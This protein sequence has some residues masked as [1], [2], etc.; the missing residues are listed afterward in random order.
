[1]SKLGQQ[2]ISKSIIYYTLSL[3]G[4]ILMGVTVAPIGAWFL[5]W[6]ALVPL[7]ILVINYTSKTDPPAPRPLPL[8]LLWGIGYH[9]VALSW[10]TGIHPMDWLGVPWLPSLTITLLCW[11]FISLW[12]GILVTV[13]A[14]LMVRL[15]RGNPWLRVL[16]GTAIWC[17]LE[18]LWSASPLWW[19][20]LAYTQSPQN[21]VILHLG[22]L[23]GPNSVTAVIVAFNGL[24]A[25]YLTQRRKGAKEEGSL[26]KGFVNG[27]LILAVSLLIISHFIGFILYTAPL[28]LTSS[29]ALKIGVIQ[30]NI[31]NKIKVLPQ[32]LRRAITGYTE[33]YLNLT[34]QGVQAVLTPE[35]SIPI[36]SRDLL[37]T[38][39]LAAIREKG[40]IAWIGAFGERGNSYTNSLF[41]V[42]GN[43]EVTSRYD[44]SKLVPLGEY[45][46]FENILGGLIQRLSPLEAH[47]VAGKAQ[48]I[49]DTP[50]GKV[51][52][53]ICYESA[54]AE[55]F[56]YQASMGGKFIL[57]SSNDAH[58]TAAMADQHHAQD[59]MR[60]IE[61]DRW[62]VRATNTGY[63]AFINPHGQTL[64]KSAYNTYQTH[65]ETIY[66]RQTQTLYVR[67]GDWLTPLLLVLSALSRIFQSLVLFCDKNPRNPYYS[68]LSSNPEQEPRPQPPPRKR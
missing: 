63:S 37:Q 49:F 3:L 65:A 4:G 35:A 15:D 23:S 57:S 27:Y 9:G 53:G 22:Q 10:I 36:F 17:G 33:G 16:F 31:P 38:P 64:W 6:I 44:K 48:Q 32:G 25:E 18:S 34:N 67:W 5:A 14:A 21:L 1:M 19:S 46:P 43:G 45:I 13:W 56:R 61:T 7:W 24:I 40:V 20:S 12:G 28:N 50:F 68:K 30:G 29:T 66:P 26:G 41:T 47:Q 42:L 51:I 11:A 58:Y 54:F 52:V 8:A 55:N 39:L 60:A 59:I 62:A 2:K